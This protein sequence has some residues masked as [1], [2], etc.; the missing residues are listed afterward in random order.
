MK[1]SEN[2]FQTDIEVKFN[3]TEI[4]RS[5]CF[6]FFHY[7][8]ISF[9]SLSNFFALSVHEALQFFLKTFNSQQILF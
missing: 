8:L 1:Q 2:K 6:S 5:S 7:I 9:L 4:G 3:K